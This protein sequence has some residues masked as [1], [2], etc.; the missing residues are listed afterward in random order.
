MDV[1]R[2][3]N[4]DGKCSVIVPIYNVEIYLP[5]CIESILAQTY[6][7]VELI[8][9]DDG[10]TD[11]S[12]RIA[13][14]YAK[15]H[16]DRILCIHQENRGLSGARNAGLKKADGEYLAFVDS[17]D[18]IDSGMLEEMISSMTLYHADAATCG[19]YNEY[20]NG[21]SST[22]FTTDSP[23]MLTFKDWMRRMLVWDKVDI[24]AWDKVYRV[25]CW[26]GIFFPEGQ[27]NEDM[28]TIPVVLARAEK[29][30]HVGRPMY[31]YRKRS[32]SITTSYSKKKVEDFYKALT[33]IRNYVVNAGMEQQMNEELTY[34]MNHS[35]LA[36]LMMISR[37]SEWGGIVK[38]LR[39]GDI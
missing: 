21:F 31:H 10:S 38:R 27:N 33:D 18:Y 8:L 20:E 23:E 30:I 35:Y 6:E 28:S 24:A 5:Q 9:V 26:E 1:Q 14:E 12:G 36:M 2:E 32:G 34:Y 29:I 4:R 22:A 7:N 19:R 16:S 17:D 15:K 13:E 3:N 37:S 39:Q 11:S 25:S